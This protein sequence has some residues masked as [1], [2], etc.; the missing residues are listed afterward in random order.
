ML[1]SV[2]DPSKGNAE[3]IKMYFDVEPCKDISKYAFFLNENDGFWLIIVLP[4]C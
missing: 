4:G 1:D 2:W 3:L